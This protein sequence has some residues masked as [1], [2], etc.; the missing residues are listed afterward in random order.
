MVKLTPEL[1][2]QSV[3]RMNPVKDRELILRGLSNE[4]QTYEFDKNSL[5]VPQD[6]KFRS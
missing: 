5:F 2:Q 4:S 1:I 3:Q 6:T